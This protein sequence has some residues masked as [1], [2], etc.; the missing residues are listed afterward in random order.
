[1]GGCKLHD[2]VCSCADCA[3]VCMF[4]Q[5]ECYPTQLLSSCPPSGGSDALRV[6][7]EAARCAR[8]ADS[9]TAAFG[10]FLELYLQSADM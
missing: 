6:N 7:R 5:G 4:A 9:M 8:Q 10:L 3:C 1:V 2:D